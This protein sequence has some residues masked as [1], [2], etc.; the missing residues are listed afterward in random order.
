[1]SA[2]IKRRD[3][4]KSSAIG[5]GALL[6]AK[7]L[8]SSVAESNSKSGKV[9]KKLIRKL[10]NTGI[11]LP[12]VSAGKLPHD[13]PKIVIAAYKRGIRHFDTAH[14]YDN[15]KNEEMLGEA[16]KGI[17]RKTYTIGTKIYI[18]NVE[19]ESGEIKGEV[20]EAKF[21]EM[22]DTSL[23]RLKTDYVDIL[24][25]HALKNYDTALNPK[26][27]EIISKARKKGLAKAIGISTHSNEPEI[28]QACIDSNVY[29]VVLTSYNYK[30][31]HKTEIEKK[32]TMAANKG[33]GVIAMKVMAGG[34]LDKEKTKPVNYKAA[35][36]WVLQNE[37]ICTAIPQMKNFDQLEMNLEL[38]TNITLTEEELKDLQETEKVLGLYCDGCNQ[39]TR[40]CKHNLPIPDIMRSYMYSFGYSDHI[41]A[42]ELLGS[43]LTDNSPCKNCQVCTVKCIKGFNVSEKM[44][45]ITRILNVPNDFLC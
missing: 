32:I 24:Y 20:S 44:R 7:T 40:M 8:G 28:I 5:A 9:V 13:N 21:F 15:G 43:V 27:L 25:I 14:G 31:E 42:K 41:K 2:I 11:E 22:F 45:D 18:E 19:R 33:I 38:M 39:C 29:N 17:K 30:Q 16:L 26:I 12:V 36:K 1:M 4:L 23:K 10:G 37:N 6:S 35:M 3:F 34:F